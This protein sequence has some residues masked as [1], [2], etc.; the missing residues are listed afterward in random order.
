MAKRNPM[1]RH[2][3][4]IVVGV[5]NFDDV[6]LGLYEPTEAGKRAARAL[7]RRVALRPD[8]RFVGHQASD[9]ELLLT[10]VYYAKGR[11]FDH[12]AQ[13]DVKK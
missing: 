6:L 8:L 5:C 11:E 1:L 13:Y 7:A 12:V 10:K 4:Y 9:T 2:T 3:G